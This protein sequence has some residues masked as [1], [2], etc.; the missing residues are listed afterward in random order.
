MTRAEF[1]HHLLMAVRVIHGPD[2]HIKTQELHTAFWHALEQT[3][4]L[5]D[6]RDACE[7]DFDPLYGI[8]AGL[9]QGMADA[10]RDLLL[11]TVLSPTAPRYRIRFDGAEART[12]L[13]TLPR[14]LQVAFYELAGRFFLAVAADRMA[15]LSICRPP[16]VR[17]PSSR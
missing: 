11:E 14:P 2:L 3:P 4:A 8:S 12:H 15:R 16:E 10:R 7:L 13:H 17:W 6:L 5:H 9:D 1:V